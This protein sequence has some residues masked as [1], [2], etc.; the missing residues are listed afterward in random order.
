MNMPP[1]AVVEEQERSQPGEP[2]AAPAN[3]APTRILNEDID[4]GAQTKPAAETVERKESRLERQ[5]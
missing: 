1:G 3:L 5:D 2:T 4:H